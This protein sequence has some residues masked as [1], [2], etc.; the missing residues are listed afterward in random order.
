MMPATCWPRPGSPAKSAT[1]IGIG[2][3]LPR[4][5][6][7]TSSARAAVTARNVAATI[8]RPRTMSARTRIRIRRRAR[9]RAHRLGFSGVGVDQPMIARIEIDHEVFPILVIGLELGRNT[10]RRAPSR[11]A[12]GGV[13][14]GPEQRVGRRVRHRRL[15]GERAVLVEA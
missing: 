14:H 8:A 11:G 15:A 1:A 9:V 6:S 12:G 3:K 10:Q 7:M 13:R 4:R 5:T 2:W